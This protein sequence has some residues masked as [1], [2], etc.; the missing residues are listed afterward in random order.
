MN[1]GPAVTPEAELT[2]GRTQPIPERNAPTLLTAVLRLSEMKFTAMTL[3][4]EG[5]VESRVT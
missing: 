5:R 3:G 4:G 1:G 2:D